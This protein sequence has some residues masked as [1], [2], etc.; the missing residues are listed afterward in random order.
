MRIDARDFDRYQEVE[1]PKRLPPPPPPVAPVQ[2]MAV[3]G[4]TPPPVSTPCPYIRDHK[5]LP[6]PTKTETKVD[7]L[8]G[9]PRT[10][11]VEVANDDYKVIEGM[12]DA[13]A[14]V[15]WKA[16]LESNDKKDVDGAINS[17]VAYRKAHPDAD[18][19]S[20][21][22]VREAA[23]L[24]ACWS[25]IPKESNGY[26]SRAKLA[27]FA[28]ANPGSPAADAARLF[29]SR[30]MFELIDGLGPDTFD[31]LAGPSN[32]DSFITQVASKD[33]VALGQFLEFAARVNSV[34]E[35]VNTDAVPAQHLRPT[36]V[37]ARRLL[38]HQHRHLGQRQHL[39]GNAAQ[40]QR[41]QA[42][43]A[44]RTHH[45]QVHALL[46]GVVDH[47]LGRAVLAKHL[48]VHAQT[49]RGGERLGLGDA[50]ARRLF[51]G[52]Q[53]VGQGL[54][55]PFREAD[56]GHGV[57]HTHH[58]EPCTIFPGQVGGELRRLVR[59]A[60]A[61]CGQKNVADHGGAPD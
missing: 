16:L 61:V 28:Q 37:L 14:R 6:Q 5:Q 49:L 44:V 38:H 43:M 54:T 24:R 3:V 8:M 15:Y 35:G 33:P 41:V 53:V 2:V 19:A 31:G 26:V 48:T 55:A 30:G 34:P 11:S 17:I 12:P 46:G 20:L 10:S 27:E 25:R 23:L 60:R 51:R 59:I 36:E 29:S 57:D 45:D 32:I 58:A 13:E 52:L 18:P 47:G 42:A 21:E 39:V 1:E 9:N 56:E 7:F 4:P 40:D 22:L 50:M